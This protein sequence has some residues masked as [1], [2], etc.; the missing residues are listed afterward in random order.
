MMSNNSD[1]HPSGSRCS[2]MPTHISLRSGTDRNGRPCFLLSDGAQGDWEFTVIVNSLKKVTRDILG[3]FGATPE[4][5]E[6]VMAVVFPGTFRGL[7]LWHG[8]R[9]ESSD[10]PSW[11][12]LPARWYGSEKP[13]WQLLTSSFH[14]QKTIT[15]MPYQQY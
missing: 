11:S 15:D 7:G 13:P 3:F 4:E 8:G 5:K 12:Q 2:G 1:D 6:A 14:N 10:A 9:G